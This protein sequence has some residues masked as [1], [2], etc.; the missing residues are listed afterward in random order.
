MNQ[1]NLQLPA[2]SPAAGPPAQ[3]V[4]SAHRPARQTAFSLVEL[5]SV[6]AIVGVLMAIGVPNYQQYVLKSNRAAAKNVLLQLAAREENF[7]ADNKQ[8][9]V[10]GTDMGFAGVTFA[11]DKDGD[12]SATVGADSI[13]EIVITQATNFDFSAT[14]TAKGKQV[15]DTDCL[16]FTIDQTG[17][18]SATS[19]DC[20]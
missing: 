11:I 6:I 8:Y 14:A 4:Q 7:F 1:A 18:R 2:A 12:G 10:D 9:T 16:T 20:W 5:M 19:S 17:S 13:Y 15:A 3:A